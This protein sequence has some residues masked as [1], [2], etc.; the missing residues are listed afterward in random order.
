MIDKLIFLLGASLFCGAI[1]FIIFMAHKPEPFKRGEF[2]PFLWQ[3]L[4]LYIVLPSVLMA[5]VWQSACDWLETS[6]SERARREQIEM[7]E[8]F[9]RT[10]M[11]RW[12]Q[13]PES[14][15]E[16]ERTLQRWD[17]AF[18][19]VLSAAEENDR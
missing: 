11:E 5:W 4:A 6:Q 16:I 13:Y 10:M 17:E 3:V 12:E 18:A 9:K 19:D 8:G 2:L 14:R 7:Y 15:E 1:G